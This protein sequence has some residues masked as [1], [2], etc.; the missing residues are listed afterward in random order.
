MGRHDGYDVSANVLWLHPWL[1][2]RSLPAPAALLSV[3]TDEHLRLPRP[4]LWPARPPHGQPLLHYQQTHG[5]RG[6][7][8]PGLPR[9]PRICGAPAGHSLPVDGSRSPAAHLVLHAPQ[10]HRCPRAHR[11]APD[12]LS[13]AERRYPPLGSGRCPGARPA[14]NHHHHS[15]LAAQP[16]VGMG[17]AVAA[18]LLATIPK[19]RIHRHRHDGPRPGYDAEEPHLPLPPRST[20]RYVHLRPL[21]RSRQSPPARPR[22]PAPQRLHG[23]GAGH[24]QPR[25]RTLAHGHR[26]GRTGRMGDDTLQHWPDCRRLLQRRLCPDLADH[27]RLCGPPPAGAQEDERGPAVAPAQP[28]SHL[29]RSP[30]PRLHPRVL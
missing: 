15:P 3:A 21:L 7:N 14:R 26:L 2:C 4:T 22:R 11:C 16:R 9:A 8:V 19:R 17:C 29:H 12:G 6:A 23:Q 20:A 28:R 18:S 1:R 10:R 25:R 13:P 30:L 24:S 27:E 5:C